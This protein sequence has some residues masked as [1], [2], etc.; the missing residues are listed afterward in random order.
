MDRDAA[1]TSLNML[2]RGQRFAVLATQGDGQPYG[3]LV[4]FAATP[5]GRRLLFVTARG[6]RK[7]AN[8]CHDPRVALV[9]DNRRNRAAD[10]HAAVAVTAVGRAGEAEASERT[11]LAALYRQR[12]PR[13]A[14]FLAAPTS[15]LLAVEVARYVVVGQFQ[16]VFEFTSP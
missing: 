14:P 13:L 10:L 15:A 3:S 6:T 5:D 11:A 4:A 2:L 9:L 16:D 7:F 8:L 1:R 12:H